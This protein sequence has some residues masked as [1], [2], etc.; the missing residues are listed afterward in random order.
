MDRYRPPTLDGWLTLDGRIAYRLRK[1]LTFA[2]V[3]TNL[4]DTS[5]NQLVKVLAFPFDYRGEGR[6]IQAALKLS[7]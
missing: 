3:G 6:R 4:T 2:V 5:S 7:Y 1:E